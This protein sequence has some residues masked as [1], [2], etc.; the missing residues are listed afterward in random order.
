[1]RVLGVDVGTRRLGWHCQTLP[2]VWRGHGRR[3]RQAPRR[4]R[5]PRPS[6]PWFGPSSSDLDAGETEGI[7]AIVV[8]LP[9][10]LNGDDTHQ[11]ALAREIAATLTELTGLTV[12]LQDERLSSLEAESRLAL[13]EKDWRK[14]KEKLDAASAAVILQD[15]LDRA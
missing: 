9:R 14:R 12:H 5:Q 1:M 4:E 10:R 2:P 6:Q 7:G 8:G 15:Y 13:R 11:T 3:F